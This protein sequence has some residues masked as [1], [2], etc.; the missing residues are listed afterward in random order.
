MKEKQHPSRLHLPPPNNDSG[1]NYLVTC[2]PPVKQIILL[3]ASIVLIAA[4]MAMVI[5]L[6]MAPYN[7][8][9][10]FGGRGDFNDFACF[11]TFIMW[12]GLSIPLISANL[13]SQ[14]DYHFIRFPVLVLGACLIS[15][16][17]LN[18]SVTSESLH[19][20]I[21]SANAYRDVTTH[22][23]WGG[24]GVM[25]SKIIPAPR[26]WVQI[27]EAVR[28]LALIFPL[29]F[30]LCLFYYTGDLIKKY[31]LRNFYNHSRLIA[32][33][34]FLNTLYALPWLYLSKFIT[35][36][37][38]GTDNLYELFAKDG[39]LGFGGGGYLYLL[40]IL[41]S[42]NAVWLSQ[43]LHRWTIKIL[44]VIVAGA[45]GWFLFN[46]GMETEVK[47]YGLTFSGVDFLLGPDRRTELP[48]TILFLRWIILYT[49]SLAIL[50][51]GMRFNLLHHLPLRKN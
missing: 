46:V 19:D 49:C 35:F 40:V 21:G 15:F 45:I 26:V 25:L 48:E 31:N 28:F 9:E 27:E 47:K 41:F 5:R 2:L 43:S 13:I 29:T 36:D 39:F 38:P 11:A 30:L 42:L 3:I 16:L 51:W 20:I 12:F 7:V 24:F 32:L 33:S 4:V 6:P 50:T 44:A 8:R 1:K 14:Q 23:M 18:Y 17:L 37:Q 10:L 22:N 34:L